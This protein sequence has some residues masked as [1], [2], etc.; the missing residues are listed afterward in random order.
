MEYTIIHA[1]ERCRFETVVEGR[2]AYVEYQRTCND[3][4]II[5]TIVP[6]PIE[7]RGIASALVK[8]AFDYAREEGLTPRAVCSYAAVWLGRHPEYI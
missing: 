2:T 7:G 6:Q 4:S 8:A 5:H 1:P 3:L